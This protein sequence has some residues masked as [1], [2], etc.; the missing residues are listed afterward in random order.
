MDV[1]LILQALHGYTDIDGEMLYFA[2]GDF[3]QVTALQEYIEVHRHLPVV[4]F[5]LRY[6]KVGLQCL[7]VVSDNLKS[8]EVP[9]GFK[10]DV[11]FRPYIEILWIVR[12]GNVEIQGF[13]EHVDERLFLPLDT[14]DIDGR[15]AV[16]DIVAF[17]REQDILYKERF[18]C[19]GY[20]SQ[21]PSRGLLTAKGGTDDPHILQHV[22]SRAHQILF[23]RIPTDGYGRRQFLLVK[24]DD[25]VFDRACDPIPGRLIGYM[26]I[27]E[28]IAGDLY[29][30]PARIRRLRRA[31]R[32][33]V[34]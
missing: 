2:Q 5:F 8:D 22:H 1:S 34:P 23:F 26:E 10:E 14:I 20:R 15:D 16:G 24:D 19:L 13:M 28:G 9:A 25:N 12:D 4:P 27:I 30:K 29:L 33:S 31:R 11:F 18:F 6:G 7:C 32:R 3:P 21:V 17:H